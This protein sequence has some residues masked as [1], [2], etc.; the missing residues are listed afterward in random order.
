MYLHQGLSTPVI[1]KTLGVSDVTIC[2]RLKEFE[3]PTRSKCE[4]IK[5]KWK[6]KEYRDKLRSHLDTIWKR[7]PHPRGTLGK[8]AWN[9]GLKGTHFSPKTEFK[10]GVHYSP[11]TELKK[12][13]I[14]K[15]RKLFLSKA[16]FVELY[17]G[18]KLSTLQIASKF[19]VSVSTANMWLKRYSIPARSQLEARQ[20]AYS[21]GRLRM[22][23]PTKPEMKFK[24]LCEERDIPFR[25]TG[26]GSFWVGYP[27][28]NPDFIHLNGK[29]IAVEIFGDYWHRNDDPQERITAFQK[30]GWDCMVFWEHEVK[31][32]DFDM[33]F[34]DALKK[35]GAL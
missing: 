23:P 33:K 30:Y 2:S 10:K 24:K 6:E 12:G 7:F 32:E 31:G 25:Y 35:I 29:K 1:A 14:P 20:L 8:P 17:Y 15:S 26:D 5:I 16:E 34:E 18:K 11:K 13:L 4:A 19:G 21:E 3:I 9:K 27:P 28:M 22:G